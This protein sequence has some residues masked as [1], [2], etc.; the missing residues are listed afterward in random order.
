MTQRHIQKINRMTARELINHPMV[1]FDKRIMQ[2]ALD[3]A[4]NK[5]KVRYKLEPVAIDFCVHYVTNVSFCSILLKKVRS[6]SSNRRIY[7][8]AWELGCRQKRT[9]VKVEWGPHMENDSPEGRIRLGVWVQVCDQERECFRQVGRRQKPPLW[10]QQIHGDAK[11]ARNTQTNR[12]EQLRHDWDSDWR[13]QNWFR[14]Q[15]Q[16]FGSDCFVASLS[17][18][19][20]LS[21][22]L[23]N[24]KFSFRLPD[25]CLVVSVVWWC[26]FPPRQS[27]PSLRSIVI[28]KLGA[29]FEQEIDDGEE[30][31][32]R[33]HSL[34]PI[35]HFFAVP[36]RPCVHHP[37]E[38]TDPSHHQKT[39]ELELIILNGFSGCILLE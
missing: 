13:K 19:I 36:E 25:P 20:I 24:S 29:Y 10:L 37:H 39:N 30:H 11:A 22:K 18:N 4:V 32:K 12:R 33:V 38:V 2:E 7:A 1:K 5:E 8:T 15:K 28:V 27:W 21:F 35:F 17:D 9:H 6:R 3:M 14:S 26:P 34:H 31:D 23:I 16:N